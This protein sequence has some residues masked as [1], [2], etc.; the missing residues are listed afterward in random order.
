ML[1]AGNRQR[2]AVHVT[3]AW[4]SSVAWACRQQQQLVALARA[5]D[6]LQLAPSPLE[7]PHRLRDIWL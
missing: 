7:R 4:S 3:C 2:V 5:V 1:H 6:L